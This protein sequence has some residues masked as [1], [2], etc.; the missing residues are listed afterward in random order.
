MLAMKRKYASVTEYVHFLKF[1]DA[2]HTR[3]HTEAEPPKVPMGGQTPCC[4]DGKSETDRHNIF[5]S[6]C[7]EQVSDSRASTNMLQSLFDALE[8]GLKRQ[9]PTLCALFP[10]ACVEFANRPKCEHSLEQSYSGM[11][12]IFQ[13]SPMLCIPYSSDCHGCF[14]MCD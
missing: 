8:A 12:S 11:Y 9:T 7:V 6:G 13:H 2:L 10:V 5:A 14:W 3:K 4:K 1:S